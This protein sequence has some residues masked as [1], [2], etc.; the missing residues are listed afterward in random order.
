MIGSLWR[1][2]HF[3]LAVIS[4]LFLIVASVTGAILAL[5]PIVETSQPYAV[6]DLN[7]VRSVSCVASGFNLV[8][9]LGATKL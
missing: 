5:E 2:S 1:Y 6:V 7:E 9:K 8:I 3:L 4:A